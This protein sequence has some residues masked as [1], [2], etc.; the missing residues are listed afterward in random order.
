MQQ[1]S[2]KGNAFN[3]KN[4][5]W[6]S[7]LTKELKGHASMFDCIL[8]VVSSEQLNLTRD[9]YLFLNY[10]EKNSS[11]VSGL[12]VCMYLVA[13]CVCLCDAGANKVGGTMS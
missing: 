6:F 1:R 12:R 13:L 4:D 11:C 5:F 10:F 3:G 8:T 7:V 9:P 2:S